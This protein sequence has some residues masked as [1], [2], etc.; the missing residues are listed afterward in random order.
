MVHF[1]DYYAF[2]I[3]ILTRDLLDTKHQKHN[4]E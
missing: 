3:C 2:D 1:E 4:S